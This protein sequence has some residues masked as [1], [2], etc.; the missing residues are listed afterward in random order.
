MASWD[1]GAAPVSAGTAG[2]RASGASGAP[3]TP[4]R[5]RPAPAAAGERRRGEA[6]GPGTPKEPAPRS[7]H[8]DPIGPASPPCA[9]P[10]GPCSVPSALYYAVGCSARVARVGRVPAGPPGRPPGA[11][12]RRA[13][14]R[15]TALRGPGEGVTLWC[16]E[17]G[18]LRARGSRA[19]R[20]PGRPAGRGVRAESP[21]RLRPDRARELSGPPR[22]RRVTHGPPTGH[23]GD[24]GRRSA[25]DGPAGHR[26]PVIRLGRESAA[27]SAGAAAA[28]SRGAPERRPLKGRR[29]TAHEGATP[30]QEAL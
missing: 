12:L 25:P 23:H 28:S 29:G 10:V 3:G 11:A 21:V 17:R 30:H 19:L 26:V 22:A 9:R 2:P 13:G 15:V 14:R 27:Q 7:S 16:G 20:E 8:R 6:A 5:G 1:S 24:T 4:G 18:R